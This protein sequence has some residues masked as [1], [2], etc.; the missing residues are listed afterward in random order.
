MELPAN[1]TITDIIDLVKARAED[2]PRL[3][4]QPQLPATNPVAGAGSTMT[5]DKIQN[6]LDDIKA[7][8]SRKPAA[9]SN[10]PAPD[11]A[12]VARQKSAFPL[13]P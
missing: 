6:L 8:G 10:D 1:P 2:G 11:L 5:T 9:P 13:C 7:G 12:G 3:P 4:R